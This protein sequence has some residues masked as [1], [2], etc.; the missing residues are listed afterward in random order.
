MMNTSVEQY[1]IDG[2]GRCPLGGTPECKVHTWGPELALL[3]SIIVESGLTEE[4]KWGSPCYTLNG[5][6]ILMLSAFKDYISISF[7]KG[8]LL[9]DE[10][11]LLQKPGPHSQSS[12]LMKFTEVQQI[13]DKAPH[14]AAYIFE[15][16]EVEKAGLTVEFKK[17]PEPIPDELEETFVNDP[18]FKAAFEALTPGRQRGYILHFSQPKQSKT[19]I[20]RIEKCTPMILSGIGLHDKYKSMKKKSPQF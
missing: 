1:F 19:R 5:K 7:F 14:I 15:A 17:N 18:A 16:I 4:A 8:V 11:Q 3:R 20:S 13:E 12:R 9:K 6:N 10:K 2:C